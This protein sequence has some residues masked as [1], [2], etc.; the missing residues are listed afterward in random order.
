MFIAGLTLPFDIRD[1]EVDR[2]HMTTLPMVV[3]PEQVLRWARSF[4][5][6]HLRRSASQCGLVELWT[7]GLRPVDAGPMVVGLQGL[8]AWW[9]L[10]PESA[11][12]RLTAAEETT[13]ERFT[14]WTLD[15]VLVM[16]YVALWLMYLMLLFVSPV[17]RG[18]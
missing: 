7:H 17:L 13:R 8:W 4:G 10:R 15:G 14:G 1:V 5:S 12:P 6:P 16:P 18:W 3:P 11:L 2:P 9:V